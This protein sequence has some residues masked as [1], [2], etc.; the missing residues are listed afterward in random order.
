MRDARW[1]ADL[2]G[3]RRK[4]VY[5]LAARY[6]IP[7]AYKFGKAWR[8]REDEVRKWVETCSLASATVRGLRVSEPPTS[9]FMEADDSYTVK[10][11]RHG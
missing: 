9:L 4:Q 2:T 3:L 10:A 11:V 6:V 1:V 5:A 7:G 8:F